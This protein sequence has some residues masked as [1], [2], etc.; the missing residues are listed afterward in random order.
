MKLSR[1][2]FFDFLMVYKKLILH[3][4][5]HNLS[6][7]VKPIN[8]I[9]KFHNKLPKYRRLHQHYL[10]CW[11]WTEG[12]Y[13][14]RCLNPTLFTR[15]TKVGPTW[16]LVPP[17]RCL[18]TEKQRNIEFPPTNGTCVVRVSMLSPHRAGC[19][20]LSWH[21]HLELSPF[22]HSLNQ[23]DEFLTSWNLQAIS[24]RR[25]YLIFGATPSA[26][27]RDLCLRGMGRG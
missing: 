22:L 25:N 24:Q 27:L 4:S 16:R 15:T 1:F 17:T 14:F 11:H 12:R 20:P 19:L 2:S 3:F 21:L 8:L 26:S 9:L 13:R 6:F 10:F 5:R 23:K 18:S 7:Q